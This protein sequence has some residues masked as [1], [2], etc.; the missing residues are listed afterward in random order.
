MG[1]RDATYELGFLPCEFSTDAA[2]HTIPKRLPSV[3]GKFVEELICHSLRLEVICIR[4]PNLRI[5]MDLV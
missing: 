5:T 2:S 3:L 1:N 4:T